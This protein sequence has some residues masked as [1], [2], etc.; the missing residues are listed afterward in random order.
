MRKISQKVASII[1]VVVLTACVFPSFLASAAPV[2]TTEPM[3]A[4]A[5]NHMV[6]LNSNGTVWAWGL[7]ASGQL[8]N[9][10]G[11]PGDYDA[12]SHTPVQ[13]QNLANVIAVDA[14]WN[15][16]AALRSD[17]TVWTWGSN[18][19]G[20]LGIGTQGW[21]ANSNI[22]VQVHG[23]TNITAISISGSHMLALRNDGTV[24]AWGANYNGEIGDGTS[25]EW[26]DITSEALHYRTTPV[27]V[28][29]L[30]NVAHISAG[31]GTSVAVLSDGTVRRW[32][33]YSFD[34]DGFFSTYATSP[35]LSPGHSN[36]VAFASASDGHFLS[37]RSDGTVWSGLD[38]P[39]Q[40][41]NLSNVTA[42]AIGSAGWS[43]GI[44]M[45]AA[46]LRTDGTVWTWGESLAWDWAGDSAERT[47]TAT[48][49]SQVQG[50]NNIIAIATNAS[51]LEAM[52]STYVTALRNDGTILTWGT[53]PPGGEWEQPTPTQVPGPNGVGHLNVLGTPTQVPP[54]TPEQPP[55]TPPITPPAQPS[56]P[57]NHSS[58]A[59]P[60]LRRA[61]EQNLI[62]ATLQPANVDLTRPITRAEFAGIVVL[63]FEN[64][65]HRVALP[66]IVNPFTDTH[67]TYVLRAFNTGLM[68]GV[69]DTRFDP[70]TPLNREQAAT[71]LTRAFKRATIPTWTFATDANY[72]LNFTWPS[73]FADDANISGWARESVYFMAAN[74]IILGTGNNMFSPRATT[75]EQQ[76]R[77]YAVATREQALIIALRMV[78]NLE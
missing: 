60:E 67:D 21:D 37:L 50:L 74:G 4:A 78:E 68:V 28:P 24:W 12:Y 34:D 17:G 49:P 33:L 8:G 69:S 71:A 38:H 46:A 30:S 64:L 39:S 40:V 13:V 76:A 47:R 1:L 20:Q 16:S 23:L 66:T 36:V 10:T 22:P 3:I 59:G 42:I 53:R 48:T 52:L 31:A 27:Q 63:T 35:T 56:V 58:W 26:C 5:H 15:N 2:F 77:G 41:Q 70:N 19:T 11:G 32:G 18:S 6:A 61:A 43:M 44:Q 55:V 45:S 65:T 72:P 73:L 57:N 75:T 14:S 25:I 7:G 9:G 29:G 62:P 54:A 51:S